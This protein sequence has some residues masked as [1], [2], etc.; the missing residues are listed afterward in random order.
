[1]NPDPWPL[2]VHPLVEA[3]RGVAAFLAPEAARVDRDGVP[4][5]H[6]EVVKRSGLLGVLGPQEYG[7]AG[8]GPAV[9]WAVTELLAAADVSTWFVQAQHHMPLRI[10][11]ASDRLDAV[12]RERLLRPLCE[13]TRLSGVIFSQLRSHPRVVIA[14]HPV[15][16][17]WTLTGTAPWFTGWG[18]A[19]TALLSG[20][21][22]DD[23]VVMGF[24]RPVEQAGLSASEP[25]QLAAMGGTSTVRLSMD[26]LFVAEE[27][28]V[29]VQ[30]Y[31]AWAAADRATVV[32]PQPA[33][34]GVA[35]AALGFLRSSGDSVA[36]RIAEGVVDAL[37][38]VREEALRLL[39][40]AQPREQLDRRLSLRVRT[41]LLMFAA[42]EAALVVGG[43]RGMALDQL[44]QRLVREA[45][46]LQVQAQTAMV[47][48]AQLDE[49]LARV[50]R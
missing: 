21:T 38:R 1:M 12:G 17:G 10:T 33:A 45:A 32:N 43:G 11:A 13:G 25:L 14:A 9:L 2:P 19:D 41:G 6:L 8:E 47:R 49:A 37:R 20:I 18:L 15:D 22:P 48:A 4:A 28:V 27:D 24:V 7:G 31:Q 50:S 26:R 30:P 42:V 46:F 44:P 23:E 39:V 16:G 5:S 40:D 35:R 36:E 29:L 34:F 3:A